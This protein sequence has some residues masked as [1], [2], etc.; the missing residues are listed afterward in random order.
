MLLFL[1]TCVR[2]MLFMLVKFSRKKNK[3]LKLVWITSTNI[4]LILS[5]IWKGN[6]VTCH[7]QSYLER[8]YGHVPY[9]VI[10]G[11][12]MWSRGEY[13]SLALFRLLCTYCMKRYLEENEADN[14]LKCPMCHQWFH[15]K[16]FEL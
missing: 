14:W 4:L 16:C 5:H 8:K 10:F 6:V 9:S 2:F 7:T 11:K 3:S 13:E 15:E 1:F 12:E